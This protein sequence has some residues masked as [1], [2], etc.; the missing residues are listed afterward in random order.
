MSKWTI[1]ELN[2]ISDIDFSISLLSERR[3][4]L[5]N[6]YAPLNTRISKAINGLEK[7]KNKAKNTDNKL[8]EISRE[9]TWDN[10]TKEDKPNEFWKVTEVLYCQLDWVK[11]N[12]PKE[13]DNN[14]ELYDIVT[15]VQG[16]L[17]A[18]GKDNYKNN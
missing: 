10:W 7:I 18:M 2:K 9:I 4:T 8:A 16:L 3:S 13:D 6:P 12:L 15:K 1:K 5:T 11:E 17:T 14:Y